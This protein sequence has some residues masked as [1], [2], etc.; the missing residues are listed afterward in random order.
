M[1]DQTTTIS[2][3]P[4]PPA[5]PAPTVPVP[6][7]PTAPET[8]T[9]SATELRQLQ[10]KLGQLMDA[11]RQRA[12]EKTKADEDEM[13]KR[14]EHEKLI[15]SLKLSNTTH[16]QTIGELREELQAQWDDLAATL[17]NDDKRLEGVFRIAKE[18]DKL[19][20]ADLRSNMAEYRKLKKLNVFDGTPPAGKG[21]PGAGKPPAKPVTPYAS[22]PPR[23]S[24]YDQL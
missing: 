17:P 1:P 10:G 22:P 20:V 8:V 5:Q 21:A 13:K 6:T 9:I 24:K 19:T 18:G 23:A 4:A 14:G 7:Q 2:T 12:A 11:D 3:P 15:D 16:E